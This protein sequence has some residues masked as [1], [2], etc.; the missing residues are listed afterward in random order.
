MNLSVNFSSQTWGIN[1]LK[2][3]N[4]LVLWFNKESLMKGGVANNI[5]PGIFFV[6]FV[7][8]LLLRAN[9]DSACSFVNKSF[10][11]YHKQIMNHSV[12]IAKI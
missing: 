6:F 1:N 12:L 3:I 5:E 9:Y 10:N 4:F 2:H 7:I 11:M 8:I